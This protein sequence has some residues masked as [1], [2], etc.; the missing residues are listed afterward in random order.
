[1]EDLV[2]PGWQDRRVFVTGHTGFKGGWLCLWL[3]ALKAHVCGYALDPPTQPNLFTALRLGD[4]I[5]DY[6][7]DIRDAQTLSRRMR[8]FAPEVVFHLAAQP[9]VRESYVDPVGTYMTNVIGTANV[10]E[11]VRQTP[12]VRA[13]VV[14]TTDKC[15]R[16]NEWVWGYREVDHLGGHDPYSGS[17]ACV[18]ILSA[19]YR[20]SYF[21]EATEERHVALATA[22]AGNVIGGGD[23]STDRLIPDLIRGF[24]AKAPVH[25]RYPDAV[26]PWQHVLE[27]LAGYLLLG[28]KLLAGESGFD[29]AW[30]FGPPEEGSLTVAQIATAMAEKWGSG[31]TWTTDPSPKRH[32]ANLLRL[33]SSKARAQLSWKPRLT[34][35]Q[36]LDWIVSWFQA[37]Q[38]GEDM[39]TLTLDQI[40]TYSR[41]Q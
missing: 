3:S 11:A 38:R 19:S 36:S 16:N 5:E 2:T 12:S 4:L 31:A 17:K 39:R 28:S 10:L 8:D 41:L 27:P 29:E 32:E 9:L 14:I 25:I 13:V 7:G 1:M 18:E 24:I 6:R 15:Y 35:E 21:H 23:W 37:W 20:S 30:N 33:D 40:A 34:M 22:R 26:R